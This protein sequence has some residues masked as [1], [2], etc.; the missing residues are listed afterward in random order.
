MH[1]RIIEQCAS[2]VERMEEWMD[3]AERHAE[4]KSINVEVLMNWQL[5]PDMA[6]FTFQIQSACEYLKGGVAGLTGLQP[7]SYWNAE[8]SIAETRELIRKTV[9][10]VR[11]VTREQLADVGGRMI[12]LAWIPEPIDAGKFLIEVI[13]PNVYFHIGNAYAILR[14]GGVDVGKRDYIGPLYPVPR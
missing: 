3:K 14:Q 12:K 7:P 1:H 6:S 13:W 10:F 11:S 5:A 8:T 2:A 4:M 9:A